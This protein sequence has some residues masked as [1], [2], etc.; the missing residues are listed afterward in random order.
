MAYSNINRSLFK[1]TTMSTKVSILSEME[2]KGPQKPEKKKIV[3]TNAITFKGSEAS[4]TM[5]SI[6]PISWKNII[7]IAKKYT[8][9]NE[10]L[11]FAY[12]TDIS[13]GVLYLGYFNDG[14]V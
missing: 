6:Y 1:L 12:D 10:D 11:M 5:P 8:R 9:T 3:F 4:S 7:L 13:T 14:I 2:A